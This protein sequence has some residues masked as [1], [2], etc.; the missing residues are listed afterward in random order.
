MRKLLKPWLLVLIGACM[1]IASAM[2]T[3]HFIVKNNEHMQLL[4]GNVRQIEQTMASHWENVSRFERDGNIALL[5][6]SQSANTNNALIPQYI[7]HLVHISASQ[8]K[9]NDAQNIIQKADKQAQFD[10]LLALIEK[11][12]KHILHVIDMLY[13]E[14]VEHEKTIA[15]L[16]ADNTRYSSIALFL[17]VFGLIFVLAKDMGRRE[18]P[19]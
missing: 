11:Q 12:R 4:Q 3:H 14:K 1:S 8:M 19:K 7:E 15:E 5:L 16:D 2:I 18:W 17:Q 9:Q 10:A 13:I 6:V